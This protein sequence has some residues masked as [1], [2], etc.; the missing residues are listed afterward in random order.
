MIEPAHGNLLTFK[1][2]ALVN[3]VNC[4]G[5]MGKGIAL[6]FK[7]AFPENF[8]A[9][10]AA[11]ALGAVK[12]GSMLIH[13]NGELFYPRWI[14]NFPTK[15]H[16]RDK[17][18]L[19]DIVTGLSALLADVQRL[20]IRSIALPALGCGLGGLEWAVV[21]RTI[22]ESFSNLPEVRVFLFE[23]SDARIA[24]MLAADR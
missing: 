20:G 16:W 1:A 11:F 14:V 18:Q 3:A 9:Y 21:R 8:K 13:D 23:P 17:S 22:E 12:P 4:V 7:K 15:R 19:E 5:I 10:E 6:Q 2:E 24:P